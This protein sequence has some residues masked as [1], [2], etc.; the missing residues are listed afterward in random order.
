M[1]L[2]MLVGIICGLLC[3]WVLQIFKFGNM[4][5]S[6]INQ[7]TGSNVNIAVYYTIFAIIGLLLS[8]IGRK[9]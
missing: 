2:R 3:A 8:F 4:V 1:W 7:V 5:I 9:K 6:A